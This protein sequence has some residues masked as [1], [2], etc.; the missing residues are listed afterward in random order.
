M[1]SS[2]RSRGFTLIELLVVIAIIGILSSIV[3]VSLNTARMKARDARRLADIDSIKKAL[4]LYYSDN[5]TYPVS[6]S[7]T[8]LN[9]TDP[10][11][12]ALVGAGSIPSVPADPQSPTYDYSYST[13]ADGQSF[14]IGFCVEADNNSYTAGCNNFVT[15]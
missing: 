11:S 4:S 1:Y 14:T 7:T 6:V 12:A 3:L 10:I 8:T 2:K 9:A 5:N 15:Q 13:P